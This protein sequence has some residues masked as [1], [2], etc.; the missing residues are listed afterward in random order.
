MH[1]LAFIMYLC[2]ACRCVVLVLQK[3][4]TT[5]KYFFVHASRL[6]LG[7]L[8]VRVTVTLGLR[9]GIG[10]GLGIRIGL[11][12][13]LGLG[14]GIADLNQIADLKLS[15]LAPIQIAEMNLTPCFNIG[16]GYGYGTVSVVGNA[17]GTVPYL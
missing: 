10:I 14:I 4:C 5:A 6:A 15:I 9:L 13:G 2:S 11:G 12:I 1:R 8:S 17:T 3:L 7:W 16:C